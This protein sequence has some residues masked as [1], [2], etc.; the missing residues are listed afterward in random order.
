MLPAVASIRVPPG[1]EAA[2]ALGRLDHRERDAILDR[3]A[4]ILVLELEEQAAG[5][6]IELPH[7]DHR[8]VA[9][10][11]Q[12]VADRQS[13]SALRS[14]PDFNAR[15]RRRPQAGKAV[16]RREHS[17]GRERDH[18]RQPAS[19]CSSGRV[20]RPAAEHAAGESA[21]HELGDDLAH[22]VGVAGFD[23]GIDVG[24]LD[25]Q[26]VEQA[27]VVDLDDVAAAI[28]DERGR[29]SPRTPGVSEISMR[30]VTTRPSRTRPR[31]QDLREQRAR[32]CCRRRS[33]SRPCGP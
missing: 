10:H 32:R 14:G 25:R 26:V 19:P 13:S 3:A 18:G 5:A 12:H 7:L 29:P 22:V 17:S 31:M 23:D 1:F 28:A 33:R 16:R 15:L 21:A 9:D 30:R 4:G 6:G 2:V 11:F 8:R 24:A 20:D 27:L